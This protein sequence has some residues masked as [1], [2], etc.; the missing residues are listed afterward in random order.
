MRKSF[1]NDEA[2]RNQLLTAISQQYGDTIT[3]KQ[4]NEYVNET[5]VDFP[6]FI[7]RE[8]KIG[9]GVFSLTH[10]ATPVAPKATIKKQ[11]AQPVAAPAMAA[12]VVSLASKRAVNV[13]ESF[14]PEK[15]GTYVAFGFFNDLK[16]IIKSA[17]FYPVYITGLSGN[18]KTF[19]IEQVCAQLNREL[20]RV[21]ITKRTDETDLIGSYELIDGNTVRREGPVITAMTRRLA[22]LLILLLVSTSL[23][24]RTPRVAVPRMVAS[25]VRTSSTRLSS[26]VSLS[27]SNRNIRRLLPSARFSRRTL[28]YSAS[29]MLRSSSC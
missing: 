14:V 6:Y 5:D 20:I 13:T 3:L 12:Q 1:Y 4:L 8:R 16:S 28:L 26:S 15:N 21:N 10:S 27:R 24:L 7:L 29:T 23:P 18:G 11:Q 2:S 17:I 9:R 19:M 22:R 25:S